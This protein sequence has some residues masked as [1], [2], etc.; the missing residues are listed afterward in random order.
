MKKNYRMEYLKEKIKINDEIVPISFVACVFIF[1]GSCL[2]GCA[3]ENMNSLNDCDRQI[4]SWSCL[5]GG[6]LWAGG[7]T[8]MLWY[9]LFR[10][11]YLYNKKMKNKDLLEEQKQDVLNNRKDI[12]AIGRGYA[13]SMLDFQ[14]Q[15]KDIRAERRVTFNPRKRSELK[16]RMKLLDAKIR[17]C[18]KMVNQNVR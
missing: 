4:R 14:A 18:Q 2:I 16:T 5:G 17:Y 8:W 7:G 9:V 13:L 1:L 12:P 11:M 15:K 10:D 6:V 3:L